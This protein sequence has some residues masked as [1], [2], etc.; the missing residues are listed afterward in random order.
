MNKSSFLKK[1][2]DRKRMWLFTGIILL[3]ILGLAGIWSLTPL[4]HYA[5]Q[6][7]L[8]RL[9]T[10]VRGQW[11]TPLAVIPAYLVANS[12]LFPNMA[13][14]GAIILTLGGF[15]G[16]ACAI[17]GSLTAA[18]LFF[19]LGRR[20]G[21]GKLG[22][23]K[24]KRFEKVRK[25][26]RKGGI[27]AVVGV[28]MIPIAPY[29]VVNI[30]AGSIDLRFRDFLIGTFIAHLPGTLTLAI[31]GEQLENAI[32]DPSTENITILLA[33]VMLGIAL[34]WGVKRYA[35]K[36]IDKAETEETGDDIGKPKP[37]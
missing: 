19:F 23:L 26:L 27:G 2:K 32:T 36:Q 1:I 28:R 34:I 17:S 14:N 29:A 30:A 6:D 12:L 31:F 20:V 16:W 21:S 4:Q 22:F 5:D 24:G 15:F 25:F 18:S 11:W 3:V 37:S 35:R 9:I 10:F 7:N 33:V 13:L 8:G